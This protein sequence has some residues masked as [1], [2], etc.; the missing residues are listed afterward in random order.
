MNTKLLTLLL[1]LFAFQTFCNA[2]KKV[3]LVIGAQNY[4]SLPPLRNSL[5]D[6]RELSKTLK[7]KGFQV[8]TLLDPKTSREMKDAIIR[9][10]NLMRDEVGGVGIIFYAGHGM[11][12]EGNNY[13]IPT[14]AKL[15]LSSDLDDKC[16]KMNAVM[17]VLNATNKSLN[18]LLLD[19]CRTLPSFSR[20]SEQGWTKVNAPRGS[21]VVFATEA[22]KVASDGNGKNGL[23]TSKLLKEINEPG[24][25]INEVFKRVKQDVYLESNEKQL[26]SV[27]D[28]SIGGDF[29]FSGVATNKAPVVTPAANKQSEV[30]ENKQPFIQQKVEPNQASAVN[31]LPGFQP[32]SKGKAV[33]YFVRVT[34]MGL[35][36]SFEYFHQDKY[37]A[38]AKGKNYVRYEC[39]PG[40]QLFWVSA[41]NKE[42]LTANLASGGTYIVIVDV[43]MGLGKS[44]VGL[45]P[46]SAS[47]VELIN[48][49]KELVKSEPPAYT[50]PEKVSE[51]NIKLRSFI[52]EKLNLYE[53]TL[54]NQ[55]VFKNISADM[56]IP[57]ELLK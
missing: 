51:M 25:N 31:F 27:E 26:P 48:R 5:S 37:F 15:E 32:P 24:L 28:N 6:A 55:K 53:T 46:L 43:A 33:V 56:A 41:Q 47:N 36:Y 40:Q 38:I 12:F 52:D 16:L 10:Q 7:A 18:I 11:Q 19:A 21:I 13:L 3:A 42:F 54:K 4:S 29:Y 20:D 23:F 8:E 44:R 34:V 39:D 30:I 49:V 17:S 50:P 14:T 35:I 45:T 22:G 9:Y 2:Q 57:P 1:V